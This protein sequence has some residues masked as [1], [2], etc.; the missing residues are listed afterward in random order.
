MCRLL[1]VKSDAPFLPREHLDPFAEIARRCRVY[2]G[3]GW[4]CAWIDE[5][6]WQLHKSIR[7]IWD[8]DV[9]PFPRTRVL[10]AHARSAFRDEGIAVENNMPFFDG[11]RVFV[12]NGEIRGVRIEEA[13]RIGAEKIFNYIKRFDR[14]D[15]EA[16]IA[17]G[18]RIIV[19][20]AA[21]LRAMNMAIV[22]AERACV[23]TR[24]SEDPDYFT[25]HV[26]RDEGG[27]RI[28]SEEYGSVGGWEPIANGALK[29]F[30]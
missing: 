13:G 15:L 23:S 10:V 28:C 22:D 14:G 8:D 25:L 9:S 18:T 3:H 20:R 12:F 21:F 2:Q 16:A 29:V 24:F 5:G 6:G 26:R 17:R 30:Q 7:P 4:G 1:I 27:F 19:R 11:R